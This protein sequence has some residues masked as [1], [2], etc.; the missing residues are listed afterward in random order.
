MSRSK[1]TESFWSRSMRKGVFLCLI[2]SASSTAIAFAP[3]GGVHVY[4]ASKT[5]VEIT[6][7]ALQSVYTSAGLTN[8]TNS[9]KEARKQFTEANKGVDADQHSSAKHFDGENFKDGQLLI[10]SALDKAVV[11]VK[12]GDFSGA[13]TSVGQALHTVQDFYAHTNWVELGHSLPSLEVGRSGA[14]NNVSPPSDAACAKVAAT[15]NVNNLTTTYL[16]SGYYGGEDRKISDYGN[17]GKCRHGGAFD[18]GPDADGSS[19]YFSILTGISKDS[20]FCLLTGAGLLDSPHSDFNPPAASVAVLATVQVFDDLKGKMTE[21]EFEALLGVGP[22]L[23]FAIDTTGSMGSVIA[24]V[25]SAV[26]SIV[27]SRLGTEQ[28]PSKYV[29]SPFN[30]PSIG[31]AIS[32]ADPTAFKSA[33]NSLFASGGGDCP[34]LSM[35]GTYVAV[36]LSDDGG[37]IFVFTDASAKDSGLYAAVS[38]L[39]ST[40]K[41]KVFFALFGSC[42]PYDPAYFSVANASGGQVFILSRSEAAAVTKLSDI[43][44]TNNAVDIENRQ[45]SVSGTNETIPFYVDSTMSKLNVSFSNIASTTMTLIRPDGLTITSASAGVTTVPLSKG[46]IYSMATPQ[47]GVWKAVI[48]GSGQY[49]LLV[50]GESTLALD[51]FSF[52]EL[53]G[54]PGHQGY[55]AI[56]GLPL[57]GTVSKAVARVSGTPEALSFEFRDLNGNTIAPFSLSDADVEA[58]RVAGDVTIPSSSFRVYAFGTNTG[59]SSFQRLIA[60]VIFPQSVVVNPPATVDLGQG[61]TTTYIFQV[62]NDGAPGTFNFAATDTA[63]FVAG[64]VP[65]SAALSTGQ[66]VLVK[67]TLNVGTAVPVGT[68]DTLTM[69][70]TSAVDANV[71][72]FAVLTSTVVGPKVVGDVNGDGVVDCGDLNLIKASFGSRTG[73]RAFNPDVDVVS[74]GIID[75]RDLSFVARLVPAG[76]VCK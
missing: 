5:H 57:I 60:T 25:R 46:V 74:N 55:Y 47:V 30:D 15:C 27:N 53:G 54:R 72:N 21:R 9:M 20:A 37:D 6:E 18:N 45:G 48:G 67:V 75:I 28:E 65:T 19:V 10:N 16:T 63:K 52:V 50:N 69:T 42:S 51:E 44:A 7:E 73:S 41:V 33:I 70:A 32:T 11:K 26:I 13:R 35:S 62:R 4:P 43:L 12:A 17:I 31:P 66:S 2:I 61:Q 8:I 39:A 14:I 29:L 68:R 76:T 3:G 38:S 56:S 59:G 71:R 58:N 49:S 36:D 1:N 23:G 22:S 40:K 34:E 24:G 64:V